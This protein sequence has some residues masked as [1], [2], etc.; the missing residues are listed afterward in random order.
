MRLA[1]FARPPVS[2]TLKAAGLSYVDQVNHHIAEIHRLQG[3]TPASDTLPAFVRAR[4]PTDVPTFPTLES[5][6]DADGQSFYI[7]YRPTH[8]SV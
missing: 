4:T 5:P 3:T 6:A 8:R 2:D 7:Y 1:C